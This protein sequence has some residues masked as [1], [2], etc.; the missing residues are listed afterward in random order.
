MAEEWE[1]W[2]KAIY[3]PAGRFFEGRR[4][5]RASPLTVPRWY[6]ATAVDAGTGAG[7]RILTMPPDPELQ[8]RYALGTEARDLLH[9][10]VVNLGL[11]AII[12]VEA[13]DVVDALLV[14]RPDLALPY[15]HPQFAQSFEEWMRFNREGIEGVRRYAGAM[16]GYDDG[17]LRPFAERVATEPLIPVEASPVRGASLVSLVRNASNAAV[18]AYSGWSH[19]PLLMLAVPVGT[20]IM[21]GARGISAGLEEGLYRRI[22]MRFTGIDPGTP[23]EP[24]ERPESQD[25]SDEDTSEPPS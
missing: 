5:E 20:V 18:I 22:V 14:T 8:A 12:D 13:D 2:S 7:F 15:S 11:E 25:E 9:A 4:E 10:T 19:H 17:L 16:L 23:G 1:E 24:D 3:V 21:G 6:E